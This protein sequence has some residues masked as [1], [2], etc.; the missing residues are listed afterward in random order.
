MSPCGMFYEGF[1]I[2]PAVFPAIAKLA[3]RPAAILARFELLQ[4]IGDACLR[5]DG[6]AFK[7]ATRPPTADL[8][9]DAFCG[10]GTAQVA[11]GGSAQIGAAQ[12]MEEQATSAGRLRGSCS[13]W[14]DGGAKRGVL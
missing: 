7:D 13:S 6:I 10:S 3:N 14:D 1:R 12:I 2:V 5:S 9:D 8:H 11:R 4:H